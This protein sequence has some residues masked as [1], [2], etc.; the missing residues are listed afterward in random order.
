MHVLQAAIDKPHLESTY[1]PRSIP[2]F[3]VMTT[4]TNVLHVLKDNQ[5]DVVQWF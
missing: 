3:I 2:V 1:L 4:N 5:L